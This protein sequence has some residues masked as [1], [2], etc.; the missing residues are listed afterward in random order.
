M[1][2]P[3]RSKLVSPHELSA[4]V[5]RCRQRQ[6]LSR[7]DVASRLDL[8]EADVVRAESHRWGSMIRVRKAILERLAGCTLEGPY[9]RVRPLDPDAS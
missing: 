5:R 2:T 1:G 7:A 6:G 3:R 8:D 4:E 9:Y